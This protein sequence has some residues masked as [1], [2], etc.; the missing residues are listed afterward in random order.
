MK[1]SASL[2]E[3]TNSAEDE[4]ENE[5]EDSQEEHA[6]VAQG[7]DDGDEGDDRKSSQKSDVCYVVLS[8]F[9]GQ[10][11]GDLIVKKGAVVK[12]LE[13]SDD[14]WWFAQDKEGNKGLVPKTYLKIDAT[15]VLSAMG[16]IPPGFRPS[17]LSKLLE[18]GTSYRASH[19][20]Q[21]RLSQ[22]ELSF[23]DL[24]L[25][26]DT[27]KVLSNVHTVRAS[28]TSSSPKKWSFSPQMSSLL[29]CLLDG[30]CFFRCDSHSPDLGI[31]FEL[32]VT[33]IRN[34]TG[35]RGDL[36]CGWAF[37]KLFDENGA[38]KPLRTQGLTVHGGTPYEGV[39]DTFRMS[40]KKG[41]ST[42]VLHQK[43]M[44]SKLPKLIIRLRSPNTR[45]GE[46]LSL[47]PDTLLGCMS[48]VPLLVLYRQLLADT[49]LLDRV[50]MQNADLICSS[51]LAT[52]PQVLDQS[53]L[54]DAFR[55]SW[56]EQENNLKRSDKKDVAVLKKLFES[57][58]MSSVFPLLFSA[59]MPDPLW[60]NEDTEAQRAR[61]IYSPTQKISLETMLSSNH[62][63]QAFSI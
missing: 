56:V 30:D 17:T 21:P 13:K 31:L 10:E 25:D 29:P 6:D 60:A 1:E 41:G 23:K 28:Y 8:S 42:G 35:E 7:D 37:L 38:L 54:M 47:L 50:T 32:G 52:F 22:S 12:I 40:T 53:D 33:Y 43:L 39:V 45:T 2:P 27:G 34:S 18:E 26:P 58:Y 46:Q 15:D 44:T 14:G 61:L 57:V 5:E 9:R 4:D 48:A 49:L 11:E 51:V 19:Y 59:E 3:G 62:K 24:Q 63:H 20:I 36:S 55:K 16:A